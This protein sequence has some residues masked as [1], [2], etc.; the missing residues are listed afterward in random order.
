MG[1]V[2]YHWLREKVVQRGAKRLW[3]FLSQVDQDYFERGK[4]KTLSR[5]NVLMEFLY[6]SIHSH[7][8]KIAVDSANMSGNSTYYIKFDEFKDMAEEWC[9]ATHRNKPQ[10]RHDEM[11]GALRVLGAEYKADK[12]L[13]WPPHQDSGI[14]MTSNWIFGLAQIGHARNNSVLWTSYRPKVVV[15]F[16]G[17]A[18]DDPAYTCEFTCELYDATTIQTLRTGSNI[19]HDTDTELH[20][21]CIE[22]MLNQR[23]DIECNEGPPNVSPDITKV[24]MYNRSLYTEDTD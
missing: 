22:I 21:S 15:H 10:W 2:H 11:Q 4:L 6:E 3:K 5:G 17:I 24:I 19:V 18:T 8:K 20:E 1:V 14:L 23:D 16:I 7:P 12:E 9:E 13:L